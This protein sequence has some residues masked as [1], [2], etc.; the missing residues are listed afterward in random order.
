MELLNKIEKV[1]APA[2]LKTRIT[3]ALRDVKILVPQKLI[4]VYAASISMFL[5]FLSTNQKTEYKTNQ[6]SEYAKAIGIDYTRS[7]YYE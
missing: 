6:T 1:E 7:T 2:Y 3:G 5:I 4:L